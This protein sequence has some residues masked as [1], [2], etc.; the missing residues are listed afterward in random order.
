[1]KKSRQEEKGT[2]EKEYVLK[3][4]TRMTRDEEK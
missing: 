3:R 1:M 2:R 4:R